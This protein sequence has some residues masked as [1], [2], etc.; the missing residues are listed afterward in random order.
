ML[1][2]ILATL[3]AAAPALG[4]AAELGPAAPQSE[5][6]A[7][8]RLLQLHKIV[9]EVVQSGQLPGAVTLLARHGKVVATDTL[10]YQDLATHTPLSRSTIFYLFSMSKPITGVAMMILYEEG[11]WRPNDPLSQYIPE[12]AD[13][14]VFA[15]LDAA[16]KPILVA[17]VHAPTI[18]ELMTHTAGFSYGFF[19]DGP[20]EAMYQKEQP[21]AAGS[22]HEMIQRI[23]RL[24]LVYQPGTK[25]LYSLSVDIQGY[26]VEKLSGQPLG[27]FMQ[28]R[29]FGPLHMVDTGF[30]VPAA[31]LPRL[32][33]IYSAESGPQGLV[34]EPRD[35]HADRP[36]GLSSGGGGLLSTAD[37][38]LRFAQMLLNGGELDG[39]RILAPRTVAL[40]RTNH[41]SPALQSGEFGIGYQRMRPGFGYGYDVAVY[42][43]PLK[44]G[45][46]MGAGT[47]LWDGAAGTWFWVDPTS[48]IVFVGMIQRRVGPHLPPVQLTSQAAVYQAL[49]EP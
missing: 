17:P 45:S 20:V 36:P 11:K 48:D 43:D 27:D 15:G 28:Q 47:F 26:L 4:F 8:E 32:A 22:L 44:A 30:Y 12:F 41:L 35:P 39:T 1:R 16:G 34:A 24:P 40:M 38:Y 18:G 2:A 3:L 37:D 13:L 25:W 42:E 49:I 14:K 29:I 31:K 6:F 9:Q 46:T 7:P 5:G 23:A 10:G 19:G 33:T 21:L